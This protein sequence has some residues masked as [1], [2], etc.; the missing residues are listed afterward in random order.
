MKKLSFYSHIYF[1]IICQD[2]KSKLSYR[3][4][5]II[6]MIAMI[7]TNIVD[8]LSFWIIFQNFPS[9][10]GW[11]YYEMI[12][13]YAFSLLA[14]TPM[15]C[16]FDNNWNLRN[17]VYSGDFVK[18]CFRPMNIFFYY[19]SEVFD[20]KGIG[21]FI[22]GLIAL[23]YS[24]PHLNIVITPILILELI[25]AFISASLFMIAIMNIAA[26]TCFWIINSGYV[27]MTMFQ[28]KGYAKYPITIFK[29]FFRFLFTFIIP[30]AFISYYPSLAFLRPNHV[31][32]L[33]W[34]TP[35]IGILFFWLSYH[36]WMKG[37]TTYNGTG[38]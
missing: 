27:M 10:M 20:I 16:L 23:I 26:A 38:S 33:T 14:L 4:D 31:S 7:S 8:F 11:N 15:Q 36:I 22:F 13:L 2:I 3:T 1:K 12:F 21:Q 18:Y 5:F 17:Y 30:I 9:I 35:V 25:I 24:W 19:M 6:S 37:A 29:G 32:I 28:F 34:L